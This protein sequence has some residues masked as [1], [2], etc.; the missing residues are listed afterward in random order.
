MKNAR[1]STKK[2]ASTAPK[3]EKSTKTKTE[4]KPKTKKV[5][6]LDAAAQ[7]LAKADK[8]M[9]AQE[10]ITAMAEKGLWTSPG[11]KTP[12]ATL[13]AAMIREIGTK[14]KDA[15]FKKVE[16][17]TQEQRDFSA[18]EQWYRKSLAIK[19]KQGNEH[20]AA[21]T[22]GQLGIVAGLQ[23][24]YEESGQWLIKCIVTLARCN[25]AHGAQ[26]SASNF[27]VFHGQAPAEVQAKLAAMWR[28]AG[29]GDLAR[30]E[31]G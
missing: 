29:L 13:Y 21:S 31:K 9:G 23:E 15:R 14:G 8:P 26:R 17:G 20:G 10:L 22:Y 18:A 30:P 16:R 1:K 24:R 3:S 2:K 19:E 7:V 4:Q 12:H 6:A 5:S 28:D 11:G 25:D 27:M